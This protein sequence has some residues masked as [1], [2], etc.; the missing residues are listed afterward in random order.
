MQLELGSRDQVVERR[1][2][3]LW[4]PGEAKPPFLLGVLGLA[5]HERTALVSVLKV[6]EPRLR[7]PV[8]VVGPAHAHAVIVARSLLRD[9]RHNGVLSGRGV[10][11]FRRD[12]DPPARGDDTEV[13]APLRVMPMLDALVAWIERCG[14]ARAPLSAAAATHDQTPGHTGT[15][16]HALLRILSQEVAHDAHVRAIGFGELSILT[17]RGR[18]RSDVPAV[19][20]REAMQSRRFVITGNCDAARRLADEELRPLRELRWAAALEGADVAHAALPARFRLTRWPDFGSLP[21]DVEHLKLSALLSG[22]VLD[23]TQ[24]CAA[25]AMT[26][27]QVVPFLAAC[28]DCGY[29]AAAESTAPLVARAPMVPARTGLFDR[30]RRRFGF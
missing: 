30:L 27:E 15:L 17:H 24:A 28:R 18:Y 3:L 21:H 16:A 25:S 7:V 22:R 9:P 12:G 2:A 6:L 10:I 5:E 4:R 11:V 29:L 14:I 19:R 13:L 26:A 20:L 1:R 8:Q 23:L